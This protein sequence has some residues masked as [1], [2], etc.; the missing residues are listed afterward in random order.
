MGGLEVLAWLN[1]KRTLAK[2]EAV[3]C[4]TGV[5]DGLY[6]ESCAR[7]ECDAE[8]GGRCLEEHRCCA[9]SRETTSEG[10]VRLV[11]IQSRAL[12]IPLCTSVLLLLLVAVKVP[13]QLGLFRVVT[14]G[15]QSALVSVR[16]G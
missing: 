2:E 11:L 7:R 15:P 5:N 1:V 10:Q 14:I 9:S 4:Q 8:G 16:S 6:E 12:Y 13:T 3:S